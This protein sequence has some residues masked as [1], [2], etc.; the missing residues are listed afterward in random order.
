MCGNTSGQK[1][2]EPILSIALSMLWLC[3]VESKLHL[4]REE[5]DLTK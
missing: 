1:R 3:H 2:Y 5:C 4:N